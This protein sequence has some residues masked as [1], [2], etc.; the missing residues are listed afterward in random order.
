MFK[1]TRRLPV[2]LLLAAASLTL[3]A[4]PAGAKQFAFDEKTN[5]QMARLLNIP[6]YFTVPDSAR[7]PL[8]ADIET[9]DRLIDFQHPDALKANAKVG[10][11]LIVARRDGLARRLA[12]SGLVQTG[13]IL[14]TFRAEWGGVG[15]YPN[16]QMGISHTGIA[17][18]RNGVVHNLDN[19]MDEEFIGS[20]RITEL[21][22]QHYRE[23]KLIHIIRPRNLTDAQR[24]NLL[25][26][27]T[28][29]NAG[30][31]RFF[32]KQVDFNQDYSDPKYSSGRPLTFVKHLGRVA[33]GQNP[34]GKV[35]MFCSE[36]A[37]SLLALR[38]CDPVKAGDVFRR[39]GMPSCIRPAMKP[40]PATGSYVSGRSH[41]AYTGLGDGP[42]VVIAALKLPR[43]KR[44]EMVKSVFTDNPRLMSRLS[45]GHRTVAKENAA[46]FA[47][48][49]G[50]YRS[51]LAGGFSGIKAR[52]MSKFISRSIRENYSPTS[53]L[54]NTLLPPNSSNRTMDYV[55]TIVIQ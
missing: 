6:V 22:S 4:P 43:Q 53:F 12:Q 40:M 1:A 26:W 41:N 3:T 27:A 48:L 52:L 13:D 35:A 16:V 51:A 14:L 8:P 46:S 21:N 30:A 49:E 39:R 10:L 25:G 24:A 42:L 50:Y 32:P 28:R 5:Q 36:F 11:R 45:E 17:Y 31:R 47:K 54:V 15:P 23:I 18:V 20:G 38:D 7:A 33:L 19:P 34:P 29:L 9:P 2:S 37:W 44:N 55:A